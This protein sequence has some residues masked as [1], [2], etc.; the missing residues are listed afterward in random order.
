MVNNQEIAGILVS[1]N[2]ATTQQVEAVWGDVTR[3]KNIGVLLVENGVLSEQTYSELL[4]YI[5]SLKKQEEKS[6]HIAPADITEEVLEEIVEPEEAKVDSVESMFLDSIPKEKKSEPVKDTV[7]VEENKVEENKV[8]E[9]KVSP[10]PFKKDSEAKPHTNKSD[11]NEIKK[12]KNTLPKEFI[13]E[14]G[15]GQ[16]KTAIPVQLGKQSSLDE[17][18]LFAR[19]LNASD[20]HLIAKT[21]ITFRKAGTIIPVSE[22]QLSSSEIE[23]KCLDALP[24]EL[25]KELRKSGD[26]EF[27]YTIIGGGRYRLT[28]IRFRGGW[29]VTARVIPMVTRSFDD[30]GFPESC[31]SL[32]NWAQGLVL[33]TGPAGA[34]KTSSLATLVEMIN[35]GRNE[36]I[37]TIEDPVE[38]IFTEGK[39]QITQRQIGM[40][41]L[42]QENA[43]KGAL[44]QD[45]DILVISELRDM[46]SIKLA[47][48]AAETGHL[49]FGTM[50]TTNAT[51]TIYRLIE[52]FPADEQSIIR[53]MV[54]ESLRGV[55]CQQLIP[56]K[57]GSGMVPC[58]EVLVVNG[59]VANMIRKNE[60][61]QLAS[62]MLTGKSDGMVMLDDS[63]LHLVKTDQIS[64]EEAYKRCTDKKTFEPYLTKA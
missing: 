6:V 47:V 58:F 50:N 10:D 27:V 63:L 46:E 53:S 60:M 38:T 8:E 15:F 7:K 61:H 3:D 56:K 59:A 4:V 28:L 19:S 62:S 36:H 16:L 12:D 35:Q 64:G 25:L 1:S 13:G 41:T 45:P 32:T 9:E 44:R 30:V 51:R 34:G 29:S 17:I 54:S 43:L 48:S 33:V 40:H 57:D 39:S 31:R 2:I 42:T 21:P 24:T 20:V 49:V 11:K 14:T 18:L 52:S 26:A 37:I 55:I 23:D 5:N 22:V